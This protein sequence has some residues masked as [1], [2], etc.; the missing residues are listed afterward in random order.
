MME[1][2]KGCVGKLSPK[3]GNM[4]LFNTMTGLRPD[5]SINAL[6]LIRTKPA[7]YVDGKRMLLLHYRFP[8]LFLRMSKKAFVSI[9]NKDILE[10]A[11][12]AAPVANYNM[13]RHRMKGIGVMMHM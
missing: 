5:E 3:S 2:I 1:W 6:S 10:M 12:Q 8:D 9:V 11:H 13:L 4:L 7:D